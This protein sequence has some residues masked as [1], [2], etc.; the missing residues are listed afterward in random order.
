MTPHDTQASE[1]T[2]A[3]GQLLR[4]LYA[5]R[6]EWLS[7]AVMRAKLKAAGYAPETRSDLGRDLHYLADS[8]L[9]EARTIGRGQLQGRITAA[10]VDIAECSV[11]PVPGV[12]CPSPDGDAAHL[13][14]EARWLIVQVSEINMPYSTKESVL[15]SAING[16]AH[17][18]SEAALRR[19]LRYLEAVGLLTIDDESPVWTARLTPTGSNVAL[20]VTGV[21]VPPGVDRVD[22]YW[23]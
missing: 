18:L 8:G 9:A 19:E 2:E 16:D 13:A 6:W 3:R 5:S 22:K 14:R 10:G 12:S 23:G 1:R 17:E 11:P 20:Y 4:A 7:E 21:D 15:L